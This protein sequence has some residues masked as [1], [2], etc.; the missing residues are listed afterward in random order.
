[1]TS[2][3]QLD[4]W[5]SATRQSFSDPDD[6]FCRQLE[7]AIQ[8]GQWLDIVY[9]GG[10]TPGQKR[11]VKPLE[12]F[13]V[14]GHDIPY[15]RVFCAT[16]QEERTFR[17]DKIVVPSSLK[18]SGGRRSE[19][20]ASKRHKTHSEQIAELV[21]STPGLK[22][23]QIAERL[24]IDR[25]RVNS[26]LHG[27]LRH[28]FHQDHKYC[29][30]PKGRGPTSGAN[31]ARVAERPSTP[32]ARLCRYYLD[33]LSQDRTDGVSVFA[34]SRYNLDY[35]ELETLPVVDERPV[36]LFSEQSAKDLLNR[37]RRDRGRL[38]MHLGYPIRLRRHCSKKG[39]EGFM[40]EPVFLFILDQDP[41]SRY[42]EPAIAGEM[43]SLNFS[44]LRTF[45]HVGSGNPTDEAIQLSEDLGLADAEASL[46]EIDE[47]VSRLR[48]VRPEWDWLEEIDP[49]KL[50][51]GPALG[52][53]TEQGI[54]NRA[55]LATSERSP[56]TQGLETELSSL[57]SVVKNSLE[58]TTLG[59]WL[60]GR[61][62]ASPTM[63]EAALL[64]VLPLNSEQREAVMRGLTN[65]LTVITG[66]PGTG[67]SQV[68]ASLLI[69]AAWQG[70]KVLFASKNNKAVDVVE[71]RVNS[72]GPRPILLRLGRGEYQRRLSEYLTSLLASSSTDEDKEHYEHHLTIQNGLEERFL[73]CEKEITSI[74]A[75]RNEIDKLEQAAR[76]TED[77]FGSAVYEKLR[78]LNLEPWENALAKLATSLRR[79][80]LE[81]QSL[82]VKF[83][84]PL[85]RAKRIKQLVETAVRLGEN[86]GELDLEVPTRLPSDCNI[87]QWLDFYE[88]VSH[89]NECASAVQ[90]YHERLQALRVSRSLED[91][92]KDRLRL[93]EELSRN[94]ESLWECWLRLQPSRMNCDERRILGEYSSLL[95]M[96][97][98][99]NESN[100]R[101][102]REV[103]RK[104]Y[105]L[106]PE[107]A[108][109]LP[110]WAVTSLSARNK[111]PFEAGFFD[112]LVIDEA[113]QCDIASC[114]PLLYRAKNV[115]V[116]GD[117]Q[118]L[119]HISTITEQ[120][121]RQLLTKH[122][123]VDAHA[124]WAYSVNSLFDLASHLCKPEDIVDLRD[125]HRSHL[126]IIEFSNQQFYGGRLRIA[127]RYD[128]L[129]TLQR[130]EPAVRWSNIKGQVVRPSA[131][132]AE[133]PTEAQAVVDELKRLCEQG[134]AGSIG[135][136]S[137]FSAQANRI[138]ELAYQDD[139]LTA[140]LVHMDF[141]AYTVH[142]FQGDE[143]DVIIFSPVVS[144]GIRDGALYFLRNNRYLFNV[145][146]TRARAALIVVGDY[147][148]CIDSGVEY[149]S[150]YATYVKRLEHDRKEPRTAKVASDFG[151]DYPN[152]AK[153]ELVSDWEH[154]LYRELYA[155]GIPTVPQY[156]ED[157]Y[158]LD[159]AL[160]DGQRKLDIEVDGERYHR[161][162][163]GELCRRDQIRN[164]RL[165]ELGW[166]VMR[167]WVY[168]VRDDM[169]HC[170]S[171]IQAWRTGGRQ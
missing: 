55:I 98:S 101:L 104:Y 57:E 152:V 56:Y 72:L 110:C 27:E 33:C 49:Y 126:D 167:F 29:W 159:F 154:V 4:D 70:K 106:F 63:G 41:S 148:A 36:S 129:R 102:G 81:K 3:Q 162:W 53:L 169:A 107:I 160:F 19:L 18:T 116:I 80:T 69:N 62:I 67:K 52:D 128:K 143:R 92:A 105:R 118:Q 73:Y 108:H 122:D 9:L 139:A 38:V 5:R 90:R 48:S 145:A 97:I 150:K 39:W 155:A 85:I 46:P 21:V 114:L 50:S 121:D 120:Q 45:A 54:Y 95:K 68:V 65:P 24:G 109:L 138:R 119:K 117:P 131:G 112:I 87:P 30:W 164:Q 83:V 171:R 77:E 82:L 157:Q 132:G 37:M 170:I 130:E 91:V 125:H 22:A 86:T 149:L 40:V 13:T 99:A 26:L 147:S 75:D 103:F 43:P 79:A 94:S 153:P 165:I 51:Q 44:V 156:E 14:D 140:R 133:N 25:A 141:L 10:S 168:Q 20:Q 161:G 134:Y 32:L 76:S 96:I 151:A 6:P 146:V 135:V 142:K 136:V 84:W 7:A 47:V 144:K 163:D 60:T 89:V 123:L 15:L 66:P 16:R 61:T 166:D 11:R 12:L 124:N 17:F 111:V 93:I 23:R 59:Q 127:T 78:S 58:S 1:M 8:K 137:P 158:I 31:K 71:D 35:A 42:S 74:V 2:D 115:V 88:Q 34:T 113:S 28:K 100:E 64:E